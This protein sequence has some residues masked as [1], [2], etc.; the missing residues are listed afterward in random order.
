MENIVE[1]FDFNKLKSGE[2]NDSGK[3]NVFKVKK[4]TKNSI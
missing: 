2:N 4:L 3:S 1:S